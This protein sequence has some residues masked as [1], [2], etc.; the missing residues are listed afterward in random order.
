M[1]ENKNN[2]WEKWNYSDNGFYFI[3]VCTKD[4]YGYFGNIVND[5]MMLNDIGIVVNNEII[6][7]IRLNNKIKIHE[8]CIMPNHIHILIQINVICDSNINIDQSVNKLQNIL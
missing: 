4:R 3:T 8:Y 1:H 7:T 2:R 5:E 6:N